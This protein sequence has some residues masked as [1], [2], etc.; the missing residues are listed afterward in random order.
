M[1]VVESVCDNL[2]HYQGT[3]DQPKSIDKVIRQGL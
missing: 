1:F 3:Y 2:V